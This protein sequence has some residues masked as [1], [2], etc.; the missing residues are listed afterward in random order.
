MLHFFKHLFKTQENNNP[1]V[2]HKPVIRTDAQKHGYEVWKLNDHK[3]YIV[4]FLHKQFETYWQ[5]QQATLADELLILNTPQSMGFIY[6]YQPI[7]TGSTEFKYLFDYLKERVVQ[8]NYKVYMS[9]VKSFARNSYEETVER[10]YLKPR[11]TWPF[12]GERV[13]QLYGNIT[14]ELLLHNDLPLQIKFVCQ[15]YSDHK[16]ASPLSFRDLTAMLLMQQ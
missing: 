10:H 1:P 2:L 7:Q 8:L 12:E 3:D 6:A 16:Y 4:G 11:F 13:N 14:I 15:P 9:D 5:E